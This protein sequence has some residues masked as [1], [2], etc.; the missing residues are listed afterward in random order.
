MDAAEFER[1]AGDLANVAPT[2]TQGSAQTSAEPP[3]VEVVRAIYEARLSGD[4][5]TDG[6][7][8]LHIR[9][10]DTG[11]AFLRLDPCRLPI[12]SPRWLAEAS[13]TEAPPAT[14]SKHGDAADVAARA[15]RALMENW[16][17]RC[18]DGRAPI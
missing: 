11:P 5:L 7:A 16:F 12:Q 2:S 4:A 1:L 15:G 14:A 10:T 6:H 8:T 17:P 9:H 3:K 13:P 18:A